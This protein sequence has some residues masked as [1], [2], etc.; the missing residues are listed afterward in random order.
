M[1]VH[2]V[3]QQVRTREQL[4]LQVVDHGTCVRVDWALCHIQLSALEVECVHEA[5]MALD[6]SEHAQLLALKLCNLKSCIPK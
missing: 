5:P 1:K 6:C 3:C 4:Q 2:S